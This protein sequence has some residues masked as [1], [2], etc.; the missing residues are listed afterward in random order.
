MRGNHLALVVCVFGLSRLNKT[1]HNLPPSP[2]TTT[3]T[4]KGSPK[5]KA[6]LHRC[7]VDGAYAVVLLGDDVPRKKEAGGDTDPV[8]QVRCDA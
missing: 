6:D 7:C 5:N 2:H 8:L 3:T 1:S 4:V